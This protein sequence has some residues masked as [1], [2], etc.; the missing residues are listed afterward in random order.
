MGDLAHADKAP[1]RNVSEGNQMSIDLSA[2]SNSPLA[3]NDIGNVRRLSAILTNI[4]TFPALGELV[5]PQYSE[6]QIA[7]WE[8]STG[9]IV[10]IYNEY[11][12]LTV[13]SFH[14]QKTV[15]C[16][17]LCIPGSPAASLKGALNPFLPATRLLPFCRK[18][19]A[20]QAFQRVQ[21]VFASRFKRPLRASQ[22]TLWIGPKS[23]GIGRP[24]ALP[25][26]SALAMLI[27]QPANFLRV[28][29]ENPD[30]SRLIQFCPDF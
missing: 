21:R 5:K 12:G 24:T 11:N 9:N 3:G 7:N 17:V 20:A 26:A 29:A 14:M 23:N 27:E 19:K 2:L 8:Q 15:L 28:F 13:P 25:A 4:L 1:P 6:K 10:K 22:R 30:K 16:R 18:T